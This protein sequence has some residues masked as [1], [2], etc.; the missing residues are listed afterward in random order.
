[1]RDM[2]KEMETFTS[3][4]AAAL[5]EAQRKYFATGRTRDVAFRLEQLERLRQAVLRH[6]GRIA[7]ALWADLRKSPEEAFLTETSIVLGEL[8]GHRRHLR[9][10]AGGRRVPTP[11]QLFP[12]RSRVMYDPLGVVLVVAPWNYPFH[13]LVN[14]LVG[15]ISAGCCAVLKASPRAPHTARVVGEMLRETF[16]PEYVTL[17]EGHREANEA[18]LAQPF[19]LVFFTGSPQTGQAVMQA[20]ARHLTPV[21]LELGGKSP[22]VV[23]RDAD[24]RRA[25]SRIVWGKTVNAGQTCVVPDYLLVHRDVAQPLV[26][27]MRRAV[28]RFFGDDPQRSPHYP[29]LVDERAFRRLTDLMQGCTVALGGEVDEADRYIAPTVL[30]GVRPD[31]PVMQEEIFGPLLPLIPF[32]RLDEAIAV[33]NSREKPLALYYFGRQKGAREVLGRTTSGGACVNDVLVHLGNPHLPFG[34]V[35]R[36]GM[37]RYHGRRSFLTFS[38]ERSVVRT[39]T[40]CDLPMRYAPFRGF[41]WVR[42]LLDK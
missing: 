5:M 42:R 10:W 6:E 35:G 4:Q 33:I 19:D 24:L 29:R 20:A 13:L 40:W 36:S 31:D 21:V 3:R 27:E 23:D 2:A 25:A 12:S 16:P 11:V 28:R 14:P 37:G 26:D 7:E 8:A 41:A 34:G 32:D 39:P 18:L 30:T 9:R 1:M 17:V 22:C 15:A 38:N